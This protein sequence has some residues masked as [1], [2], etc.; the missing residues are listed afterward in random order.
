MKQHLNSRIAV[1]AILLLLTSAFAPIIANNA[2]AASPNLNVITKDDKGNTITGYWVEVTQGGTTVKT[3]FSPVSFTLAAGS[4]GVGVGDYGSYFFKQW[5][6]GTTARF[7]PITITAT[8]VVSLTAIY[9]TQSTPPPSSGI[10]VLSKYVDGTSL[11]GMYVTL[12]QNGA[13]IA[14]GFTPKTFTA[15]TAGKQYTIIPADYTNAYFNKWSDGSTVREK[16]VTA[17]ST[18]V[19]LTALYTTSPSATPDFS[20]SASPSSLSLNTGS[21]G[22]YTISIKSVNSYS[23]SVSLSLTSPSIAGVTA[24]FNPTSV[25]PPAGGTVTSTLTISVASTASPG[26]Y[27]LKI[28]GTGTGSLSHSTTTT[29]VISKAGGTI[30]VYAHRIPSPNWDPCFAKTCSAGT[31]P[32][33]AMYFVLYDRSGYFVQSGFADEHGYTFAGLDTSKIYYLVYPAD[34]VSCHNS[35]HDVIFDHWDD[36]SKTRPRSVNIGLAAHAWFAIVTH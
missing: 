2:F 10:T 13:T 14:T 27:Q 32:G 30:T 4:Y 20:I 36:G 11:T 26:T 22:K 15:V 17:T 5:S 1:I 8:G 25:T 35:T 23:S 28:T 29:L 6:D 12:Q 7:H 9:S 34:C 31:G 18:G 24:T 33:A 21:S 16:T 3:G 19:S